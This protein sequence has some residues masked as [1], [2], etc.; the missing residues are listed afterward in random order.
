M[1]R[2]FITAGLAALVGMASAAT[3]TSDGN[4]VSAVQITDVFL[5]DRLLPRDGEKP[6][7]LTAGQHNTLT[8]RYR[9]TPS[10]GAG[11]PTRLI[12]RMEGVDHDWRDA[13]VAMSLTL[14]FFDRK[15]A[16]TNNKVFFL[17][18]RSGG[19]RGTLEE[20]FFSTHRETF[21]VPADAYYVTASLSSGDAPEMLGVLCMAKLRLFRVEPDGSRRKVVDFGVRPAPGAQNG[22]LTPDNWIATPDRAGLARA[23]RVRGLEALLLHA[24]STDDRSATWNVPLSQDC[25]VMRGGLYEV[26]WQ[27]IY[28]L[29][30]GAAAE[31]RYTG[32]KPGKYRFHVADATIN[33]VKAGSGATLDIVLQ[34]PFWQRL[35]FHLV[36]V[37]SMLILLVGVWRYTSARRTRRQ[38][39]QQERETALQRERT[40]IAQDL[41][42]S[43]GAGLTQIAMMSDTA[44]NDAAGSDAIRSKLDGISSH[45]GHLA[46][47]LRVV[48]WAISPDHDSLESVVSYLCSATTNI[49]KAAAIPFRLDIPDELPGLELESRVRHHLLM[50]A[51]E[52]LHNV[53]KHA[54]ATLVEIR[55]QVGDKA[56]VLEIVDNGKG[57]PTASTASDETG[58]NGQKNMRHRMAVLGGTCEIDSTPGQGTRVRLTI[59]MPL[60]DA[61]RGSAATPGAGS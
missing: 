31:A 2:V 25:A 40:R 34:A 1:M 60:R 45:V 5:D 27:E 55:L 16:A 18:G 59:P 47:H 54:A 22:M 15:G 44:S 33:G 50:A 4:K 23:A 46:R 35:W 10:T 48:A 29:G 11:L 19:W 36:A 21:T 39:Q 7:Q 42:D 13:P 32:M 56:L 17:L 37:P 6:L 61:K 26:Q 41:H 8:L 24:Q 14:A 28:S 57:L 9:R 58:G 20:S 49:L 52:A 51:Q 3:N 53:V 12:Y 43:V 30:S 38:L